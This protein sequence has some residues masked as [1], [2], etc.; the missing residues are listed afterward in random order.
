PAGA[1]AGRLMRV[2]V[3]AHG[4]PPQVQG[5]SEIYAHDHAR[6]LR[7]RCGDEVFVLTREQDASRPEYDVRLEDRDGLRV[8]WVNNTF[9]ATTS[10][11]DS[12]RNPA[13]AHLAARLVDEWRPA[14]A[15][16][17][18]L[19]CLSTEI[20]DVL[21]SRRIPIVYTLHDYWLLCHRGQRLD[22]RYEICDG[23]GPDGCGACVHPG[24]DAPIPAGAVPALRAIEARLPK[25]VGDAGRR[26][27]TAITPDVLPVSSA[28]A[29]RTRHMRGVLRRIDR[30][31]AP[32]HAM[33]DWF[34]GQGVPAEKIGF[35]PYGL[36]PAPLRSV[37]RA[38]GPRLRIGYI[39]TL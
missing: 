13:I 25:A 37:S 39:G 18:H 28:S 20:V 31:L 14:V 29:V 1:V 2:L 12:Y 15:H 36:D 33:R 35:S 11:E 3:I 22:T 38:R 19:T 17:H 32:S 30:F 4:F 7:E 23:P 9:R 6:A 24:A 10:F 5:G 21:A 27:V 16:A 8:A 34:I 26:L